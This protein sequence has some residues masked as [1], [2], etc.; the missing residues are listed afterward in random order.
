MLQF[1]SRAS[2][3]RFCQPRDH[4]TVQRPDSR[5]LQRQ[6]QGLQ[7][8]QP[9]QQ[10]YLRRSALPWHTWPEVTVRLGGLLPTET[11]YNLWRNFATEGNIVLIELFEGRDGN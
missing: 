6:P 2:P 1:D 10:V 3:R 5:R 11:T 8:T 4:S 7:I 9:Y